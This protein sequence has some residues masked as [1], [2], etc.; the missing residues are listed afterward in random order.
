[1]IGKEVKLSTKAL[2]LLS[3]YSEAKGI[4]PSQ[5]LEQLVPKTRKQA[6]NGIL[7]K[8]RRLSEK[9]ADR[10]LAAPRT[11]AMPDREAGKFARAAVR[12]YRAK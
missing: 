11:K 10:L 4:T 9:Q 7:R 5:A 2:K 12:R 3:E 1:M 8:A 6:V